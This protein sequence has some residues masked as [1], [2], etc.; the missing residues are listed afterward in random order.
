MLFNSTPVEELISEI[1]AFLQENNY[2]WLVARDLKLEGCDISFMA[3]K[4]FNIMYIVP[5]EFSFDDI[6]CHRLSIYMC[7]GSSTIKMLHI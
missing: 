5:Q 7:Q 1:T 3:I 4:L 2:R 6:R